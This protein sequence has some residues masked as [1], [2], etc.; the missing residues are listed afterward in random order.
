MKIETP[1][2]TFF[3]SQILHIILTDCWH[4]STIWQN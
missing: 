2:S 4:N 3:I 1:S